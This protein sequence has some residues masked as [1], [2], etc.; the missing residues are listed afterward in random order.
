M[1]PLIE[2]RDYAY[3]L[4]T[5][6]AGRNTARRTAYYPDGGC[7]WCGNPAHRR[8]KWGGNPH[9][10]QYAHVYGAPWARQPE[11][12]GLYCSVACYRKHRAYVSPY[13]IAGAA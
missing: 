10:Y 8:G 2:G 13:P 12:P 5:S 1:R 4:G 9:L 7:H 3:T 6:S 11:M